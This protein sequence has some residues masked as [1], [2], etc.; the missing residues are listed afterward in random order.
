VEPTWAARRLGVVEIFTKPELD[1]RRHRW[2]YWCRIR[3]K[4]MIRDFERAPD[5]D[6]LNVHGGRDFRRT[7]MQMDYAILED[8]EYERAAAAL[9]AAA[10][11][12]RGDIVEPPFA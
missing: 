10:D 5:L 4:L 7:V 9:S 11:A 2:P 1:A 8:A 12:A 6:V 3:P